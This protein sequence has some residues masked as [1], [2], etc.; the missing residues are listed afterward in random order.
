MA[1]KVSSTNQLK[2]KDWCLHCRYNT[3]ENEQFH[4]M[5][6]CF[7]LSHCVAFNLGYCK[8]ER[9]GKGEFKGK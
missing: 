5:W 6:G 9:Q 7:F 1:K 3:G 4:F 2:M 8:A